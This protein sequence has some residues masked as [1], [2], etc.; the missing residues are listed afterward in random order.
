MTNYNLVPDRFVNL[1][2]K[3]CSAI[4]HTNSHD[5]HLSITFVHLRYYIAGYPP[6]QTNFD[7][8]KN[9]AFFTTLHHKIRKRKVFHLRNMI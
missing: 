4:T 2:V 6:S 5:V 8:L 7:K 1:T 9:I 3:Q